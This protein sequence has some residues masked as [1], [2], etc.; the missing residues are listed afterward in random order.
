MFLYPKERPRAKNRMEIQRGASATF[1]E[2]RTQSQ[3][4]LLHQV[5]LSATI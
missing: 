1:I 3:K 4:A 2:V 5:D